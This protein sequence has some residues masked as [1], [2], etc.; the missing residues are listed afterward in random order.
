MALAKMKLHSNYTVDGPQQSVALAR[1]AN[2]DPVLESVRVQKR[3]H[4]LTSP[5]Q[6][7]CNFNKTKKGRENIR[8]S[9]ICMIFS[10]AFCV[11]VANDLT[12]CNHTQIAL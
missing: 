7:H 11:T 4:G 5:S 12:R 10:A 3:G 9:E 1:T 6:K 2:E 8:K